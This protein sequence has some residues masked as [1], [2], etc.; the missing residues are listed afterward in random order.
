MDNAKALRVLEKEAGLA[1]EAPLPEGH[2]WIKHV[3]KLGDLSV[4]PKTHIAMLGTALLAKAT[5]P[6]V[7]V[8]ALKVGAGTKGAYSA[9]AL[10]KDVLAANAPRLKIDLGV[11]GREPLNNQ[12]YFRGTRIDD[13][14]A[15]VVRRDALPA[16]EYVRKLLGILTGLSQTDAAI[17]LRAFLQVRR[18]LKGQYK[19]PAASLGVLEGSF[20]NAVRTFVQNDS[21]GGKRAQAVAAGLLDVMYSPEDVL[22]SRVNDPD[23]HFPGDVAVSGAE[24]TDVSRAFEVRDKPV[25]ENDLYHFVEK[26]SERGVRRAAVVAVSATQTPVG[27][28]RVMRHAQERGVVFAFYDS[29]NHLVNDVLFHSENDPQAM[30]DGA[31]GT[32]LARLEELEISKE[33]VELWLRLS[34]EMERIDR[35]R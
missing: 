25:T 20:V 17:A 8:F 34:E 13:D 26:A 23:R 11:S 4:G 35:T 28:D 31:V 1:I 10:A 14:L 33:G 12:P 16:F 5:D 22:V 30:L 24:P 3:R 27:T 29:W 15:A 2:E 9:R 32:V 21:E 6:T 7:D 19:V 18:K